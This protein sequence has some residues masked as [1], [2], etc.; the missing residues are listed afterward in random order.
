ML[1]NLILAIMLLSTLSSVGAPQN[2]LPLRIGADQTGG[3][4]FAG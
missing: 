3:N 2:S 4:A 1:K